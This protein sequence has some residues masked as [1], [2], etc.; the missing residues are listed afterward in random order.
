M[1]KLV[2]TITCDSSVLTPSKSGKNVI[3]PALLLPECV[4]ATC[5][6]KPIAGITVSSVY[7]AP[8]IAAVLEPVSAKPIKTPAPK[9]AQ[10]AQA[11]ESFQATQ[12]DQKAILL[13]KLID[14]LS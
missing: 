8:E 9:K 6:G 4:T 5:N 1:S 3:I 7:M 11:P 14:L 10:T 2:I 13:Q 12:A